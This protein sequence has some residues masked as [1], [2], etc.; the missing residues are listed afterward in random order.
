[1]Y[2]TQLRST[3]VTSKVRFI[4]ELANYI[5]NMIIKS[6]I[7]TNEPNWNTKPS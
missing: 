6:S 3:Q 7:T 5:E 1:M 2:Q 4:K